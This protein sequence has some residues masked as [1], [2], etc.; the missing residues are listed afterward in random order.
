MDCTEQDQTGRLAEDEILEIILS[1][2][3]L[4]NNEIAE[5]YHESSSFLEICEDYALCLNSIKNFETSKDR[6]ME[7]ELAELKSALSDLKEEILSMI[8]IIH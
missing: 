5:L 1:E 3:P 2:F 6:P 8:R 4:L 7:K